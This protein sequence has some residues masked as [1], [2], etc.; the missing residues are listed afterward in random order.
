VKKYVGRL[1]YGWVWI[2]CYQAE[3]PQYETKDEARQV[4]ARHAEQARLA[5]EADGVVNRTSRP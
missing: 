5:A 3:A 2:V 1:S 4:G